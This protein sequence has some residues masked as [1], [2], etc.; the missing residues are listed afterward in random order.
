MIFINI[1]VLIFEILYYSMFMKFARK[2]GKFWKYLL[3]FTLVTI[4]GLFIPTNILI[5]Y[6]YLV[7]IILYGLKYIIKLKTSLYDMLFVLIMIFTKTL[8]EFIVCMIIYFFTKDTVISI[9]IANIIK[10]LSL[11]LFKNLIN[12][13]YIKLNKKWQ[14]N[15]FYIR[16]IFSCLTY[17]YIII[18]IL[19]ILFR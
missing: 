7:L 10:I 16:Y 3:L 8:I 5:S 4:S 17:I 9:F 11:L 15:N 19:F 14:N 1:I 2:E 18:S 6:I 13:Y 12:R